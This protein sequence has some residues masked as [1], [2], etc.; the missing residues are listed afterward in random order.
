[1][2]EKFETDPFELLKKE[3][4]PDITSRVSYEI[5]RSAE[6][7]PLAEVREPFHLPLQLEFAEGNATL[8]L[9]PWNEE[10]TPRAKSNVLAKVNSDPRS[11]LLD[12]SDVTSWIIIDGASVENHSTDEE[13][14]VLAKDCNIA[15]RKITE[16]KLVTEIGVRPEDLARY[17]NEIEVSKALG[18]VRHHPHGHLLQWVPSS[19]Q[20]FTPPLKNISQSYFM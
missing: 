15:Y 12:N 9:Y 10:E 20:Y 18:L 14:G 2:S 6:R 8:Q 11:L 1:M 5:L 3:M 7:L 16:Q 13:I 19:Q 17:R 4:E